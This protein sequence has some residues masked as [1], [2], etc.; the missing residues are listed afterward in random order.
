MQLWE[1]PRLSAITFEELRQSG[2]LYSPLTSLS[3]LTRL[4]L[5]CNY[6][7]PA[8]LGQLTDLQ[9]LVSGRVCCSMGN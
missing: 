4:Q 2:D 1:L 6:R 5:F 7:L 8:C 3:A 9:A